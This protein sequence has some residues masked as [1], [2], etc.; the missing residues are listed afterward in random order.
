MLHWAGHW[1]LPALLGGL[2]GGEAGELL[3]DAAR[4]YEDHERDAGDS[5]AAA[6][7]AGTYSKARGAPPW[8]TAGLGNP[9][10]RVP[11]FQ[12]VAVLSSQG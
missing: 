1:L 12:S 8:A 2:R 7:Q 3:G 6:L 11:G 9:S 10:M 4:L 5:I